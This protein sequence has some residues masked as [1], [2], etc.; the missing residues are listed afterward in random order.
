MKK[1]KVLTFPPLNSESL[2]R[3]GRVQGKASSQKRP[4]KQ[5][6]CVREM[7][8]AKEHY[9]ANKPRAKKC[10]TQNRCKECILLAIVM[11]MDRDFTRKVMDVALP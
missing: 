9:L 2:L 6:R 10:N 7:L 4:Q 5:G 11:P 8:G 1:K 3:K